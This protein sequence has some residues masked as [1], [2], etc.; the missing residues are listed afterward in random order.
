MLYLS[1]LFVD[2]VLFT[3]NHNFFFLGWIFHCKYLPFQM[4]V[5]IFFILTFK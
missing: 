5:Q 2:I 3:L 4:S 1:F